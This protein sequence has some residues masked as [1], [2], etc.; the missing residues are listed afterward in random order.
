MMTKYLKKVV[1]TK[2]VSYQRIP[3]KFWTIQSSDI[4]THLQFKQDAKPINNW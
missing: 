3:K 4:Q 1:P 2:Y